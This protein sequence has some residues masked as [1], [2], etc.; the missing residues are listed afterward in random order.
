MIFKESDVDVTPSQVLIS[1]AA[2]IF[3]DVEKVGSEI[4]YRC[5]KCRSCKECKNADHIEAKSI[6][7][8][9]EEDLIA[10]SVTIDLENRQ[11]MASYH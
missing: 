1:K 8:E 10:R 9:V 4:T 7:E 11:S 5:V 3:E 6:K 2:A